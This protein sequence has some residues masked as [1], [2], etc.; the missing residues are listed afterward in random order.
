MPNALVEKN[1]NTVGDVAAAD[2]GP[3]DVVDVV[4]VVA[5]VAAVTG[6]DG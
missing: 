2:S 6:A 5:A 1:R 3:S 4:D